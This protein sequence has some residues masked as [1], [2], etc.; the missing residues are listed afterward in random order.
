MTKGRAVAH[1]GMSGGGWTESKKSYLDK[2]DSQPS[3]ST[4]SHGTPGQAWQAL[5]D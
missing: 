2:S 1:L 4:S 5:R 3:P